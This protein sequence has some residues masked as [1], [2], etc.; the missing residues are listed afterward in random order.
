[1]DFRQLEDTYY[2]ARLS[3]LSQVAPK[4]MAEENDKD[5]HLLVIIQQV[6]LTDSIVAR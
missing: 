6:T 5:V 2:V 3:S 4:A 1:M